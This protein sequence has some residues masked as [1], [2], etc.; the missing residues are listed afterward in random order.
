MHMITNPSSRDHAEVDLG[1]AAGVSDRGLRH[2]RNEDAMALAAEQAPDGP[3]VVA[4]VCD[5]VSSSARPD[6]ASLVAS[7]AAM[8]VLV[9]A[10]QA[11]RAPGRGRPAGSRRRHLGDDVRVRDRAR[12]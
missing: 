12:L 2:H 11:G 10:V 1:P 4:V 7:E 9:A 6:Q 3:T 8:P 5:G